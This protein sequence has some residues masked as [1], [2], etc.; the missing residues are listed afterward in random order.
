MYYIYIKKGKVMIWKVLGIEQTKDKEMIRNAYHE[1]LHFVNPE[2]D[3][4]GF[5]ELRRAYEEAMEYADIIEDDKAIDDGEVEDEST[6]RSDKNKTEVDHWIDGIDK[7]YV[8]AVTRRDVDKWN[9]LLNDPICDDL[10]TELEAS[11][12]LLVYIMSHSY[13]PMNV[14]QAIDKRFHYID[15]MDQLKEHFPEE[16]LSY[17]K[18]QTNHQGFVDFDL[19]E[20]DTSCNVDKYIN[21][22]HELKNAEE[23]RNFTRIDKLIGE[24]E[25]A[26][27]SHPYLYVEKAIVNLLQAGEIPELLSDDQQ[28]DSDQNGT[29]LTTDEDKDK[30]RKSALNIMENIDFEYSQ[31]SYIHRV[32]GEAL[33]ANHKTEQAKEVFEEL[34]ET[35]PL[36]Y[37][38]LL[39][40]AKCT[41]IEGNY[42]LAKE[43]L[44]DILEERVQDVETLRYLEVVNETLVEI[45][46]KKL[47]DGLDKD[48]VIKL[49][50]CYYQQREFE[51][52]IELL[53]EL[54]KSMDY[55]YV[56]LRCRLYLANDDYEKAYPWAKEWLK[57]IV[58]SVDDGSKEMTKRK[59]RLS[60]AHF[61]LG[62]C[63]W[64]NAVKN[65][66]IDDNEEEAVSFIQK[67][68]DEENNQLV[69]LSYMEQLA[70]FYLAA[71]EYEKCVDKCTE[72]ID[73]D[74][75]FFPAYVHRQ[76]ANFELRQAREVIEDYYACTDIYPEYAPPYILAA[77]VFYAFEQYDD[78]ESVINK[79][80]EVKIDSDALELYKVRL[81][82]YKDFS[83]ENLKKALNS[84]EKLKKRVGERTGEDPTDIEK[85]EDIYR[86]YAVICW[87]M[88]EDEKA[89]RI[90]DE[91]LD[92]NPECT[93]LMLLKSD[94]LLRS[95]NEK[96]A[97]EISKKIY[98]ISPTVYHQT[99]LGITY[100]RINDYDNAL[101]NYK[102][103]YEKDSRDAGVV[104]RLMYLYSFLSDK[105]RDLELCRLGIRYASEFIDITNAPEGYV[106]RGNLYIDLYELEKAVE[107]C[108]KAI[109]LNPEAYYAYNNLGCALLK[110]R[111]VDEAIPPLEH[112]IEMDRE[113]DHL[114]FLNLAEC[115][116]VKKEY[117]KAIQQY[118]SL[119]E[120]FPKHTY[121]LKDIAELYCKMHMYSK[122]IEY[123]EKQ[124]KETLKKI[125]QKG[126][127]ESLKGNEKENV[128]EEEQLMKLYCDLADVYRQAG[129][130]GKAETYY[131]KVLKRWK[132]IMKTHISV[133][134]I[135]SIAE[136]YRDS[137]Q[138]EKAVKLVK[139]A[140]GKM[141][142]NDRKSTVWKQLSFAAATIYFEAKDNLNAKNE[143]RIYFEQFRKWEGEFDKALSDARYKPCNL[144]NI[145]IIYLCMGD[146]DKAKEFISRISDCNLCVMCECADCFEYY[147]GM[148]LIAEVEGRKDE[149]VKCYEKAIEIKGD[150]P[151]AENHL[152]ICKR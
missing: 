31:N 127:L 13:L 108:R 75:G 134:P 87:D 122:A 135:I 93:S 30:L 96:E 113:K 17:V 83:D 1:K 66:T 88:D 55:D 61:S 94:I 54:G 131:E 149:A 38:A 82:H 120:I 148:G 84:I 25:E 141:T 104:R 109:E 95:G 28:K 9:E 52:G 78:V 10:D 27:I 73:I 81:L 71:E 68:I 126:I 32:Y 42:E 56:N 37:S 53:D 58:E 21:K 64:E 115:Y 8:D 24:L 119:L 138:L 2:D 34:L 15:G 20:G 145:G 11:E 41:I 22:L 50:W 72:I 23:E 151:C 57:Q 60:L 112:T 128:A 129:D 132:N 16:F 125:P 146:I 133:K 124:I 3:Q 114:P 144:Y 152:S 77:E 105:K 43:Q 89:L 143:G 59:N 49:G 5:K 142:G 99:R 85:I 100:E 150:Y 91:F 101:K 67:S 14:W 106:E 123:Y 79:A 111:R 44:E 121:V 26:D 139:I 86:E 76:K 40:R 33:L 118:K 18:W 117:D 12:K 80:A 65:D 70:R 130:I 147:F 107:D 48:T 90:L 116:T 103:A 35:D 140:F 45:Y 39:C 46:S 51:K 98:K 29:E 63:I 69:K 36:S 102:E 6:E 110:L 97:L 92:G 62:V 7:I 4:E 136:Y 47:E 19:F 137:G 74:Q